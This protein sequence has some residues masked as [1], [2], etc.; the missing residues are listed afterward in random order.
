MRDVQSPLA[1]GTLIGLVIFWL[2]KNIKDFRPN[3]VP[4]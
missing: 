2:A 4:Q 1:Q 3:S